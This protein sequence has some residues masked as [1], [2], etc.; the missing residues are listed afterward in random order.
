[1]SFW[2]ESVKLH[3][4]LSLLLCMRFVEGREIIWSVEYRIVLSSISRTETNFL[5]KTISNLI[6]SAKL[7]T[8]CAHVA[9]YLVCLHAH[10][11]TCLACVCAYMPICF[12]YLRAHIPRCLPCLCD[13]IP[14][15]LD[16]LHAPMHCALHAYVLA[17][18]VLHTYSC[19]LSSHV[20]FCQRALYA[21]LVR[22]YNLK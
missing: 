20:L 18:R 11:A 15:Y 1:M 8:L 7:C 10:V 3:S 22:C 21:Y 6:E 13:Y 16:C 19:A 17:C 14:M 2:F 4:N 9:M 12:A 5:T